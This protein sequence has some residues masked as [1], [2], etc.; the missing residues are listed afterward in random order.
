MS[1][2]ASSIGARS[3]TARV[4]DARTDAEST[5]YCCA[6]ARA[7]GMNAAAPSATRS[8]RRLGRSMSLRE[9]Q[10]RLREF[11]GLGE[12]H[13]RGRGIAPM[14]VLG[15]PVFQAALADDETVRDADELLVGEEHARALV[16]IVDERF[17]AGRGELG[18]ELLGRGA[19]RFALVITEG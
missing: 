6:P 14:L 16:A 15:D 12:R 8:A 2:S 11:R 5:S 7:S 9:T 3:F 4:S 18:V 19:N 13:A 17:H 1:R 10:L